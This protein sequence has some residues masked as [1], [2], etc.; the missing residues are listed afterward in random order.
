MLLMRASPW[1][2]LDHDVAERAWDDI[3]GYQQQH[4]TTI[5]LTVVLIKYY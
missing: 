2:C 4:L 5:N 1:N 3:S